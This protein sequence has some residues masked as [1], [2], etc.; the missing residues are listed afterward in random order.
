MME[1]PSVIVPHLGWHWN[2][3]RTLATEVS[4]RLSS[5]RN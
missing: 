3:G 4:V 5:S 1:I 2:R